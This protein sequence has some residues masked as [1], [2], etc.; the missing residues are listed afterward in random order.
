MDGAALKQVIEE[1][2]KCWEMMG[3]RMSDSGDSTGDSIFSS[4][5]SLWDGDLQQQHYAIH[6][7]QHRGTIHE[8]FACW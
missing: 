4:H 8:L 6:L 1:D 7:Y 5:G 3:H 2:Q